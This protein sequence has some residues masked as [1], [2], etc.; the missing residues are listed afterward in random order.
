MKRL[1][2]LAG[3]AALPLLGLASSGDVLIPVEIRGGRFFAVPRSSDGQIFR[4]WLDTDGSGFVFDSA[5]ERFRLRTDALNGMRVAA[6]PYFMPGKGIPPLPAGSSLPIIAQRDTVSDP[7]LKGFDAQLGRTWFADR[8][9]LLDFACARIK[10]LDRPMPWRSAPAALNFENGYPYV[11][12]H[13]PPDAPALMMSFDIAASVA[14]SA[15]DPTPPAVEATS[16]VRRVVLEHWHSIHPDWP[17]HR[18]VSTIRDVDEISVPLLRVGTT[19]FADVAFTTRPADD[20]FEGSSLDGKLGANAYR[21][22]TVAIDY[23]G[24]KIEWTTTQHCAT[25]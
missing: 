25:R 21:M 11:P 18:N 20:V 5:V 9:W 7:I 23:P 1:S 6:L 17:V 13:A 14:Y 4:C 10:M 8:R 16:F 2:F 22:S 19:L 24:A 15:H 3:T 12:V